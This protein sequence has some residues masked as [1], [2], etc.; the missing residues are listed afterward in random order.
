MAKRAIKS[1]LDPSGIKNK[2]NTCFFNASLQCFISL[3]EIVRYFL[4]KQFD[5]TRQ[6]FSYALQNFIFK[7]KN[8]KIVDPCDLI[9]T[10][11]TKIKLFDG[12]QHDAQSFLEYLISFLSLESSFPDTKKNFINQMLNVTVEDTIKCHNCWFEAKNTTYPCMLYLFVT[13]S[14]QNSLDSFLNEPEPIDPN[15]NW[16]CPKCYNES[17]NN[18]FESSMIHSINDT[19]EYIIVHL[20]RYRS[21]TEKN[22]RLTYIEDQ[23][24]VRNIVYENI[25]VVCHS[26]ELISGHYYSYAKRDAWYE[27]NDSITTPS[28]KPFESSSAY[29]LFYAKKPAL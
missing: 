10:L 28:K 1:Y 27:F 3:P 4:T 20:N 14:I 12:R 2:G 29:I 22:D 25:G 11:K 16:N 17:N 19:S 7:Y 24:V 15:N 21:I 5:P 26:G 9:S 23:L 6:P 13:D 8:D 18:S